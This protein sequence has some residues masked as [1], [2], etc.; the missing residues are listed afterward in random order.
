[1][2]SDQVKFLSLNSAASH[3]MATSSSPAPSISGVGSMNQGVHRAQNLPPATT[4]APPV[5]SGQPL[6][7]FT[8][9]Q[10]PSQMH[11]T[12]YPSTIAAPQASHPIAPPQPPPLP[13]SSQRTPPAQLDAWDDTYMAVLGTQDPKQLRELLA[14]STPEVVMP[15][16]RKGPLS[17]A[18]IL[19]IL[20]RVS[21]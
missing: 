6:G 10:Q 2:L 5:Y 18:V 14:R 8:Q 7:S 9:P 21:R 4:Q 3:R 19:S 13:L 15:L 11:P 17:M 12:W 20:H 16:D 1:M